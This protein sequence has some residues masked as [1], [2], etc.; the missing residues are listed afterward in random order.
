[1]NSD[2]F[3]EFLLNVH[4]PDMSE[5]TASSIIARCRRLE[6]ALSIELDNVPDVQA[7]CSAVSKV[8]GLKNVQSDLRSALRRYH[9]FK[10][11]TAI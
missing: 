7:L 6:R 3:R 9:D 11:R 4:D 10:V 2:G 8:S 5:M 1:M